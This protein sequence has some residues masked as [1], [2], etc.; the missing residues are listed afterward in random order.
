MHDMSER[1]LLPERGDKRDVVQ[2]GRDWVYNKW[3]TG[4]T[5]ASDCH[6]PITIDNM[7]Y[8]DVD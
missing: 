2:H 8:A 5:Q 4:A 1:L 7:L 3:G 6:S